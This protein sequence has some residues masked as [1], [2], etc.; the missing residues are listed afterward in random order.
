MAQARKKIGVVVIDMLNPEPSRRGVVFQSIAELQA[1]AG[2]RKCM[3]LCGS[4]EPSALFAEGKKTALIVREKPRREHVLEKITKMGSVQDDYYFMLHFQDEAQ[5][6][7]YENCAKLL[8]AADSWG[9]PIAIVGTEGAA[10]TN[11]MIVEAAGKGAE[12]FLKKFSN[13]VD[14]P[15][16]VEY[17]CGKMDEFVVAGFR[18]CRCVFCSTTGIMD[19]LKKKAIVCGSLLGGCEWDYIWLNRSVDLFYKNNTEYYRTLDGLLAALKR[20]ISLE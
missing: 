10:R 4:W 18:K 1:Y 6:R 16:F 7:V 20:K 2:I 14:A 15:G 8:R 11:P 5:R 3:P 12:P 9:M 13:A 17:V 19:A